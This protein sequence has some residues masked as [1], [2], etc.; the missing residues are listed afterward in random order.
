MARAIRVLV[1]DDTEAVRD[2]VTETLTAF[3][4]QA[5]SV[6]SGRAALKL[7]A[8]SC[9]F[10]VILADVVM[11]DID[12]VQLAETLRKAYPGLPVVLMT[13]RDSVQLAETLR[14]AYPGL[15]VVLMT[16]RDSLV[17][18]IVEAGVV[19]LLKPFGA[20]Q[21]MRVINDALSHRH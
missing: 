4:I 8:G 15:P 18:G 1:V 12:G 17:D 7:C 9:P 14:K 13:G 3:G 5:G 21:L 6:I 11:G 16:G 10:D 19:P 20:L 2:A